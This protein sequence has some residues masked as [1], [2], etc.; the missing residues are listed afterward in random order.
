MSIDFQE[1]ENISDQGDQKGHDAPG[2]ESD[3]ARRLAFSGLK[4]SIQCFQGIS[5]S[6]VDVNGSLI[7]GVIVPTQILT[8][9]VFIDVIMWFATVKDVNKFT[10]S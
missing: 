9:A 5:W 8:E 2:R 10:H 7:G 1:S 6:I 4:Q 3:V